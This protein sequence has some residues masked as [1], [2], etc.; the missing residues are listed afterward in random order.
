MCTQ[1]TVN[2]ICAQNRHKLKTDDGLF[3]LFP[4]APNFGA[5]LVKSVL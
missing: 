5:R 4:I 1:Q 2:A 3:N